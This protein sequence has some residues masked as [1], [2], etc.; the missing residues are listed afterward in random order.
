MG[1]PRILGTPANIVKENDMHQSLT[2]HAAALL[3]A[4]P[5]FA[6][7]GAVQA[8]CKGMPEAGCAGDAACTWVS[9]YTRK[10]GIAVNG[11]CRTR[12]GKRPAAA[13]EP[14]PVAGDEAPAEDKVTAVIR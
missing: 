12:S 1:N 11:Y 6:A 5:F 2:R 7:T 13:P 4:V 10:D 14:A 8:A 9:A 3:L